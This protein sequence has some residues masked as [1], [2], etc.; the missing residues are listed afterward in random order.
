MDEFISRAEHEEFMRRLPPKTYPHNKRRGILEATVDKIGN[1]TVSVER[2]AMS[3]QTMAG[4]LKAQGDRIEKVE[5][6][7]GEKWRTV[8]SHILT[9]IVGAI[10]AWG[11]SRIGI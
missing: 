9:A 11:L 6:R 10:V 7:D 4:E 8:T 3:V 1:L 5:G 2:L